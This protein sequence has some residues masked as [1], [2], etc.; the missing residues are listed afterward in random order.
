MIPISLFCIHP[1]AALRI[2][3]RFSIYE[4]TSSICPKNIIFDSKKR[5]I[6]RNGKKD[7][8]NTRQFAR[9]SGIALNFFSISKPRS[10]KCK[11]LLKLLFRMHYN[12][13]IWN[14]NSIFIQRKFNLFKK[15]PFGSP[16]HF[17]L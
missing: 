3:S 5:L 17:F 12:L 8:E 7:A 9:I 15:P 11:T 1:K 14:L 16:V 6:F 10:L 13:S 2:C 4:K